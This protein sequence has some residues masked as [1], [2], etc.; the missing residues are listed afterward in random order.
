MFNIFSL[1]GC[2]QTIRLFAFLHILLRR[3]SIF[4][5]IESSKWGVVSQSIDYRPMATF[6]LPSL[7]DQPDSRDNQRSPDDPVEGDPLFEN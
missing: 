1:E 3:S 7:F 6:R 4:S 2:L 5:N